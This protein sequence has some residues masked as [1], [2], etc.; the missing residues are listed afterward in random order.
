M[1]HLIFLDMNTFGYYWRFFS[2]RRFQKND[3][4]KFFAN[5]CFTIATK[6]KNISLY[7]A[8]AELIAS[9]KDAFVLD[10]GV[11]CAINGL[12]RQIDVF[13]YSTP[14]C[15]IPLD[16]GQKVYPMT[17]AFMLYEELSKNNAL[18]LLSKDGKQQKRLPFG[19]G[20]RPEKTSADGKV[21]W[22]TGNTEKDGKTTIKKQ[23][24]TDS[25]FK[26]IEL[27]SFHRIDF[28]PD[29]AFI[30]YFNDEFEIGGCALYNAGGNRVLCSS[31]DFGIR[32]LGH[33][34][35]Y[36][37]NLLVN[38]DGEIIG[39]YNGEITVFSAISIRSYK[40]GKNGYW[41]GGKM[42]YGKGADGPFIYYWHDGLFY[43][44]PIYGYS[45]A[46]AKRKHLSEKID[47]SGY[48]FSDN[49]LYLKRLFEMCAD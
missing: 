1:F 20:I 35:V 49:P 22:I 13:L 5:G 19:N 8:K 17:N 7:S 34:V 27:P 4:L 37:N 11:I 10:N 42:E 29:G 38:F 16:D 30:A 2:T 26:E 45:K 6:E 23:L 12:N 9:Y 31:Q 39:E 14:M 36:E 44:C 15:S 33:A 32:A 25:S 43:L 18:Y 3:E 28:L 21:L 48:N 40:I 24:L 41:L 47:E 46:T